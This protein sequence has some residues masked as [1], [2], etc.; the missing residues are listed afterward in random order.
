[1]FVNIA[2]AAEKIKLVPNIYYLGNQNKRL[3]G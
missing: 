1:L 2:A 3:S